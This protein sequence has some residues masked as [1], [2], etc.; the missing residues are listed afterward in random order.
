VT[1]GVRNWV[2]QETAGEVIVGQRL[3]R[4]DR[5]L[6]KLERLHSMRLTQMEDIG[7]C[8]A[9]LR[10]PAEVEAVARRIRRKWDVQ[11]ESD[12]R[13]LGK[14]ITG[15]RSLHVIV[16]RRERLVEVQLRTTGQQYWA[17]V[18][19]RTSS[20]TGIKLKDGDGP[21][22]LIEY[23]R[24]ASDITWQQENGIRV[25]QDLRAEL[26]NLRPQVARYFQRDR[27]PGRR[28]R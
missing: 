16:E 22:R 24:V 26:A 27:R 8:R 18:V 11:G 12:Y 7:G 3:K 15:Y 5:I 9:V 13:E 10:T 28:R 21:R 20:R 4:F 6:D 25:D 14:P 19:E 1:P 2:S 17:E 23:F